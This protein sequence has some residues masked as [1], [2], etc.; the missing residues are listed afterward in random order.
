MEEIRTVGV[1]GAGTM[2]Q[3]IAQVCATQGF[4]TYLYDLNPLQ[5]DRAIR[6]IQAGLSGLV[7]KGK[8][9]LPE[10]EGVI[11]RIHLAADLASLSVDLIIEAA[12]ERLEIKQQLFAELENLLAGHAILATNTSS[13]SVSQIATRLRDP[14]RCIGLHFFNPAE[15]MKLVE[16]ISGAATS[17][18]VRDQVIHFSRVIGKTPVLAKDSPGFIVNRV[19]RHFYV[20]S[21]KLLADRAADVAGIDRL[22]RASG[23]KMGPFELM[24]LIGVDT[25]LAVTTSIYEGFGRAHKFT[26]SPI[27]Q[28]LV[29][30]GRLGRKS[31]HGFY[32]YESKS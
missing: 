11:K 5:A 18:G 7:Q 21:L 17:P 6:Q 2:G 23:F 30:E 22:M 13:I 8:M 1:V 32:P 19:A 20:E 28:Q 3:G 27:Q 26:P 16:V 12:V 10:A 4:Q 29:L 9:P 24:D 15:R 31:G 14:S 25:N